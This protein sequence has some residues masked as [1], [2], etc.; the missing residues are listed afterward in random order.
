MR[1]ALTTRVRVLGIPGSPAA[2]RA[3]GGAFR[4]Q[5]LDRGPGR[6]HVALVPTTALLLAGDHV[7]VEVEV[8]TGCRLEVTEPTGTVAYDMH[9]DSAAWEL[10]VRVGDG[11]GVVWG[12]PEL[13]VSEGARV[14]RRTTLR[15]E[16]DATCLLRETLVLGRAGETAGRL[17]TSTEVTR[18]GRPVLV[19]ELAAGPGA[20]V[21]GVLGRHRVVDQVLDLRTGAAPDDVPE[22]GDTTRLRLEAGGVL[23]RRLADSA[24][25]GC[26]DALWAGLVRAHAGAA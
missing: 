13:V 12:T 8:G 26:L 21:P 11:S 14:R 22:P 9:G 23:H 4:V 19:E 5:V 25:Q 17:L 2:V 3:A 6:A 20:Q 16:G 24:H 1:E 18:D 10:D 15:L 7:R